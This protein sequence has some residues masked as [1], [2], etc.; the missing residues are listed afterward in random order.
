[1]T[2]KHAN[3]HAMMPQK[4]TQCRGIHTQLTHQVLS[5]SALIKYINE[6]RDW[7][8]ADVGAKTLEELKLSHG[9]TIVSVHAKAQVRGQYSLFSPFLF[10][11]VFSLFIHYYFLRDASVFCL[12][13]CVCARMYLSRQCVL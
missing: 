9:P 11:P 7:L 8:M 10:P 5:Q 6:H 12:F 13:V 4:H 2:R 3:A 1:M